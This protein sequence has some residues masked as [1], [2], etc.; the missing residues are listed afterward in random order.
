MATSSRAKRSGAPSAAGPLSREQLL[1]AYKT[2]LLSRR[3]D[4]K[5]IQLKRQNKIFFQI[6]SAGHEAITTAA[7]MALR[8][9]YDWF[10]LYYR[11]RAICLTLGMTPAEMLYSAVGAAAD[12]N[13]GGRQ[14]PSHWGYKKANVVSVSSPT[15]TQFLQAA[16]AAEAAIRAEK[17]GM[18]DGFHGDEVVLVTTG[19]GQTSEGEFYESLST[20]SNLGLP[21]VYLVE[22]N[23]YA[24][25]VPVEVNTPGGSISEIVK[26]FPGLYVQQVD[27]CDFMA[28]YETMQRA[29]QHARE[30]RGPALVHART[31]RPYSHSLSDD[32]VLYRPAE[33]RESDAARDPIARFPEWLVAQG[34]A[35]EA[36]IKR[37]QDEVDAEALAAVDDALAQP[38]PGAETIHFAVY[39]PDVDPTG[40]QFDTEEDPQFSGDPTTMVDLLNACMKDEMRRDPRILVFGEDVADVSRE[41]YLER[42]AAAVPA[43]SDGLMSVLD[44]LAPTDKP[45]RKGS[46]L[47]FDARQFVG[48]PALLLRQRRETLALI[49]TLELNLLVIPL[50]V[51][52]AREILGPGKWLCP[53]QKVVL[54]TDPA[55]ARAIARRTLGFSLHLPN[56]RNNFLRMGFTDADLAAL[57]SGNILRVMERVEAVAKSLSATAPDDSIDPLAR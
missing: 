35:T 41:Q 18:A 28:S 42:E 38:Q 13:S 44:F 25:S 11:D 3:V 4:D 7:A 55:R 43:G 6:S 47:G 31:I 57:T 30:R 54:E 56:Y 36:D 17:L 46:M 52:M 16:G 15:G 40:E 5:E 2:M 22:D 9:A 45:F 20:A 8:P 21:I 49:V 12:P 48:E 1:A 51:E 23:G 24:I 33:E 53:E 19:E 29:V 34:H 39:S 14:M 50:I 26:G 37:I 10:Y 27:G 32:E